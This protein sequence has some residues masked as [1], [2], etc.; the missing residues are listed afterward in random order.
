MPNRLRSSSPWDS[1]LKKTPPRTSA[2]IASRDGPP[3]P[4][5][6]SAILPI[7]V[8][9]RLS[10]TKYPRSSR[11]F[12]ASDRPAPDRPVITVKSTISWLW[13][14]L[15]FRP[16]V[17]ATSARP[18]LSGLGGSAAVEPLVDR[19]CHGRPQSRRGLQLLHGGR[20]EPSHRTEPLQQG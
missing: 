18:S 6:S 17:V 4:P 11:H 16:V 13:L 7:R 15:G 5:P 9:G 1:S 2:T 20:P 10:T 3:A 12:A 8:G 19:P 14:R